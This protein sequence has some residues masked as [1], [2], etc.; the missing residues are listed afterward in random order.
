[1][2]RYHVIISS[3]VFLA[4]RFFHSRAVCHRVSGWLAEQMTHP[5]T[6]HIYEWNSFDL[7]L[8]DHKTAEWFLKEHNRYVGVPKGSFLR[9][10]STIE[11]NGTRHTRK[12]SYAG[13]A[14]PENTSHT[15]TA[16]SYQMLL[17]PVKRADVKRG[18]LGLREIGIWKAKSKKWALCT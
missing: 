3:H 11:D 14:M 15:N 17:S 16:L 2:V 13:G 5:V 9:Y 1:M 8:V 18:F 6:P 12:P 10:P 7:W 4:M